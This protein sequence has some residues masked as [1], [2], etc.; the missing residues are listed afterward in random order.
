MNLFLELGLEFQ[1]SGALERLEEEMGTTDVNHYE[2]QEMLNGAVR[3]R[4]LEQLE[5]HPDALWARDDFS[6]LDKLPGARGAEKLHF[7]LQSFP[8]LARLALFAFHTPLPFPPPNA[9]DTI[10]RLSF[11]ALNK[12]SSTAAHSILSRSTHI[13]TLDYSPNLIS[14]NDE[15]PLTSCLSLSFP[16]L[17]TLRIQHDSYSATTPNS[18]S[19]LLLSAVGSALHTLVLHNTATS[20]L[21]ALSKIPCPEN[22]RR[23]FIS[24]REKAIAAS[25]IPLRDFLLSA[26]HLEHFVIS[27]T[28]IATLL[29]FLPSTLITIVAEA[30]SPA[31]ITNRVTKIIEGSRHLTSIRRM[32]LYYPD[33]KLLLVKQLE[34]EWKKEMEERG[35]GLEI[36]GKAWGPGLGTRELDEFLELWEEDVGGSR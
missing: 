15:T 17:E 31:T 34:G 29:P 26:S 36:E 23:L 33:N 18:L 8:N 9:I 19:L 24:G 3:S 20:R 2:E 35:V 21:E 14:Y 6:S 4:L 32:N 28:E 5:R 13:K 7:L 12:V 22:L 16:V 27:S 30:H 11:L 1:R 25:F 10:S